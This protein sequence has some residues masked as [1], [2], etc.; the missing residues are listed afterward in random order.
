MESSV[1]SRPL[2]ARDNL[3][4]ALALRSGTPA[5]R[6]RCA[7]PGTTEGAE[8]QESAVVSRGGSA[9]EGSRSFIFALRRAARPHSY[10]ETRQHGVSY[11]WLLLFLLMSAGLSLFYLPASRTHLEDCSTCRLLAR[12]GKTGSPLPCFP[13]MQR[14]R[15]SSKGSC[16]LNTSSPSCPPSAG[17]RGSVP[18]SAPAPLRRVEPFAPVIQEPCFVLS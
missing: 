9:P 16:S 10:L 13:H 15:P 12:I 5:G 7:L 1:S 8:A 18:V 14:H 4:A 6:P 3:A 11:P 17:T 2:G